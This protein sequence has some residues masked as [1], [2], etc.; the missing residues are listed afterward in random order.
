MPKIE[1]INELYFYESIIMIFIMLLCGFIG[2]FIGKDWYK[3]IMK[4][5]KRK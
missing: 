4:Y 5:F 1:I 2:V 3:S